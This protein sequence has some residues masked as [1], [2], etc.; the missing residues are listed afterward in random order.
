[1][2]LMRGL[3]AGATAGAL[4]GFP[5][6]VVAWRR[7]A[8]L[9]DSTRAAGTLLGRPTIPRGIAAHVVVSL[10][11]GVV[12]SALLPGRRKVWFGLQ[13]GGAIAVVDLGVIGRRYPAIVALGRGNQA[14]DHLAYGAIAAATLA[15]CERVSWPG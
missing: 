8:N 9:W 12:L 1:V 13:A 6:T 2:V 10:G 3:L 11:W 14:L 15:W 7:G 4:S 5:S